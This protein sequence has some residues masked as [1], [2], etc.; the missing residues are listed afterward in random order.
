MEKMN[1]SKSFFIKLKKNYCRGR[2]RILK[3]RIQ[4]PIQSLL[5]FLTWIALFF[6]RGVYGHNC[7]KRDRLIEITG[8]EA[9]GKHYC[10]S[11]RFPFCLTVTIYNP[12]R[13]DLSFKACLLPPVVLH[14]IQL[15]A[16]NQV[17]S[18]YQ[19]LLK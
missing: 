18:E 14:Q 1:R 15:L 11:P 4:E 6:K 7:I 13:I 8:D 9:G 16:R 5:R 12:L 17:S 3:L 10:A 2:E 19:Y